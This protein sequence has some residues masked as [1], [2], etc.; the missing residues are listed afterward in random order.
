MP[1]GRAVLVTGATRGIGAG[2]AARLGRAGW[3]VE[4]C[5][6]ARDD[7]A[8]A[9]R[10]LARAEGWSERITLSRCDI[11]DDAARSRW[12]DAALGR[13]GGC[14]AL[15]HA[16]GPF[17]RAPLFAQEPA[18]WRALYDAN[19]IALHA[20]AAAAAPS[21]RAAR[22]GRIVGFGLA[23]T[24]RASAPPVIAAYYCAK[25][26][27]TALVRALA[28]ELAPDGVTANLVSPGVID[29]GGLAPDELARLRAQVPAGEVGAV[30]DAVAAVAWLLS[31]EARYV[32]G[33]ELPVAGGW[34]L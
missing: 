26:A 8:D 15:V 21:M 12:C 20:L 25:L 30:S 23:S 1:E 24:P 2:V 31:D 18:A 9:L 28:R 14:D 32:T 13:L 3:R 5:Y 7:A 10:D 29:S 6:R 33:A 22:W 27:T 19:V 16:A 11:G 34:G 4:G 17:L